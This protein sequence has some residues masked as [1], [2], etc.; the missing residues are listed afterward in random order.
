MMGNDL[1][2]NGSGYKDPTAYQAIQNADNGS[3]YDRR[4]WALIKALLK[5]VNAIF[6]AAGLKVIG[7]IT[8]KDILTGKKYR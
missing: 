5:Q 3:S 4:K 7:H 1:R 8:L 2:K 6:G